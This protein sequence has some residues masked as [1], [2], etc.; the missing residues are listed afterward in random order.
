MDQAVDD[1]VHAVYG[2]VLD[3]E[4]WPVALSGI[5]TLAD[6]PHAAMMDVDF[7]AG[8]VYRELLHGIDEEDN[9]IYLQ[10]FASIDP[11]IPIL[12]GNNKLA[13]L[14]DYDYFDDA[15]RKKDRFYREYMQPRGAGEALCLT[16]AREGSRLGTF[17]VVRDDVQGRYGAVHHQTLAFVTPHIDRAIK[18]S[19]RFTAIASEAILGHAVL[20]AL[21]EPLACVLTDGRV[22][23]ANRAF[24][25]SLRSGHVM[26]NKN[27]ILQVADPAIRA[28]F[29]RAIREC[30]R[31][32]EGGTGED[33]NAQFTLRVD[34]RSGMPSFVTIAPL[35]AVHLKSWAGRSCALV[36]IDEPAREVAVEKLTE[37][38]G[39]SPAEA[40]LVS[41][42]CAGGTLASVAQRI[43]ITLNTAK[44]QL[45]SVFSK[46]GTTRQ[47]ELLTIVAALPRHV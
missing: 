28:Q 35:A 34:H 1:F 19:R 4:L 20:D 32:A 27:G 33:P 16:C 31:I 8:A 12:L 9:R 22:H 37:A 14:S 39:V 13:W 45:A 29:V 10:E 7:A 36:R 5:A 11:R 46:T 30:C 42:L 23:R 44:T 25:D 15:F 26:S 2:A 3:P 6:A 38:L 21:N 43:G 47:S 17:T 40:R 24:D 18:L 41:E